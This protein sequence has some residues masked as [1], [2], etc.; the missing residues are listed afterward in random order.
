MASGLLKQIKFRCG[1]PLS[2][3]SKMIEKYD[4]VMRQSPQDLEYNEDGEAI[5][6]IC[7][8]NLVRVMLIRKQ[9]SDS[10]CT[11]EVEISIFPHNSKSSEMMG[12]LIQSAM[13]HLEYLNALHQQGMDIEIL[14]K[15]CLWVACQSFLKTPK[16]DFFEVLCPP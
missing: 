14:S 3:T 2:Q 9:E 4:Q 11:I 13:S 1:D 6:T 15:N 16:K 5:S 7:Q 10:P 12:P 8:T